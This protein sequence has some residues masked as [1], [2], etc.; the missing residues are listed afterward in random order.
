MIDFPGLSYF[1]NSRWAETNM[2]S[3]LTAAATW[4]RA[5]PVIV[6]YADIFYRAK[7][8]HDLASAS[9][10]LV[11]CYDRAW[12]GLWSRR[13]VDPLSDAETFRVDASGQLMEIGGRAARI[14]DIGGQYMG[15]LKFT[16]TAWSAVEVHLETI[17]APTRDKLDMTGLLGRLLAC[18]SFPITTVWTEGQWG[19]IDSPGDVSLYQTMIREGELSIEEV[20][21]Q[22]QTQK[23][24]SASPVAEGALV[25]T[26]ATS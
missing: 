23:I 6:S 4:L 12:R 21:S 13:F 17:A 16:P 19:E 20:A 25:R 1:T 18:G 26:K 3:S 9:G 11:I 2:V 10:Q 24:S 22:V 5:G 14:D 7:L 8:V 15:L